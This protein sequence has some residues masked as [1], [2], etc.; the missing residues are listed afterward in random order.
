MNRPWFPFYVGDYT[1][2]TARLTTEAHGAYLLL[3][4]DYWVNG[5][6][7]D[8]NEV[9]ATITKLPVSIWRK[10]RASILP[11][12]KVVDGRWTHRRIDREI[13][14]ADEKH[15]KRVEAGKEGGK[16]K[17]KGKQTASNASPEPPALPYQSQ[18]QPPSEPIQDSK[19]GES[20]SRPGLKLVDEGQPMPIDENY[21]PSDRAE[22]YAFSLGMKRTDLNSELSKFI[23]LSM[24]SRAKSYNPDMSFK[25]WC[26]RWLDFKRQKDPNWKPEP[27]APAVPIVDQSNWK[28]VLEGTLEHTCWNIYR[29]EQGMRPLFLCKQ[30]GA[31]GKVYERA[32][33][34]ETLFP[35][36]FNDFGERVAPSEEN[37]A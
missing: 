6:P 9:L 26:D 36:G 28:I 31:D 16:A 8:D 11:F 13:A 2:D 19:K 30:L 14:A 3:I 32:A 7:P 34:C 1:R 22:E 33:K 23:A 24:A 21:Q 35:P 18:S 5:P 29:R 27:E 17:A 10:R 20:N 15:Q 37:A 4:L 12:F 25:A